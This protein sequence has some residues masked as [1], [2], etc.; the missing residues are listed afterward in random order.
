MLFGPKRLLPLA[1]AVLATTVILCAAPLVPTQPQLPDE[2]RCLN[3]IERVEIV[4]DDLT[5][6]LRPRVT[7][8]T[9]TRRWTEMLEEAGFAVM[10][11]DA[12]HD[13]RL[14]LQYF[15]TKDDTAGA[16]A[17]LTTVISVHQ[18]VR[19][20]RLDEAMTLPVSSVAVTTTCTPK[21]AGE[22]SLREL[23]RATR[24]FVRFVERAG[25]EQ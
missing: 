9:L 12:P 5:P 10:P 18:R 3:G 8:A 11:P 16:C 1:G 22:T 14:V 2:L 17:A 6:L 7:S 13:A 20:E 24:Y 23:E 15:T 25:G 4:V 19:L 21:T